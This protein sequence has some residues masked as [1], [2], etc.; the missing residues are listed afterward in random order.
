M[1]NTKVFQNV[2]KV[3]KKILIVTKYWDKQKTLDIYETATQKFP[4]I[5]FGL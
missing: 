2:Q 3:Q 1:L 4:D 5:I